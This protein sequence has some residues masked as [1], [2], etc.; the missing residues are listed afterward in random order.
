MFILLLAGVVASHQRA[1]IPSDLELRL[2]DVDLEPF[3]LN[4]TEWVVI[5]NQ[6]YPD[7]WLRKT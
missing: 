2:L 7:L 6:G 1:G 5:H 4:H 3:S